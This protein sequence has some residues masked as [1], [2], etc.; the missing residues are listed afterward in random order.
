M[1]T[2]DSVEI[3]HVD[4]RK[5][6][7][8]ATGYHV[9]LPKK[10]VEVSSFRDADSVT[11]LVGKDVIIISTKEPSEILSKITRKPNFKK[12]EE[13]AKLYGFDERDAKIASELSER[14]FKLIEPDELIIAI[15]EDD[16]NKELQ[17]YLIGENTNKYDVIAKELE[18]YNTPNVVVIPAKSRD[19]ITGRIIH[20]TK[21]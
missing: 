20:V 3:L 19:E 8:N 16:N 1:T 2:L 21:K 14:L 13:M 5:L 18:N 17:I 12:I 15:E 7:K 4:R 10:A 6:S 9:N 11:V